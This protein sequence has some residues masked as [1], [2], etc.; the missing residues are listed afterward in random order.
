MN[1]E[2]TV[3]TASLFVCA[4]AASVVTVLF[5]SAALEKALPRRGAA[6]PVLNAVENMIVVVQLSLLEYKGEA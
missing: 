6:R 5:T 4:L 1:V 2:L 3:G